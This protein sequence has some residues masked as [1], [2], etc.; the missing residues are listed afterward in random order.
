MLDYLIINKY[1]KLGGA[2]FFY[3]LYIIIIIIIANLHEEDTYSLL[4]M[5][6]FLFLIGNELLIFDMTND[7]YLVSGQS[8]VSAPSNRY[9]YEKIKYQRT[10]S[11][12]KF[13]FSFGTLL[14]SV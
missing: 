2:R 12:V 1:Q 6:S 13:V 8:W 3:F 5:T 4:K 10:S 14:R 9:T 11:I 7:L